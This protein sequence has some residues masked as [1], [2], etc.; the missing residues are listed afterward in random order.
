M[1]LTAMAGFMCLRLEPRPVAAMFS[2]R[3]ICPAMPTVH[4]RRN[5]GYWPDGGLA[6]VPALEP[7]SAAG[8]L[9]AC[10][11]GAMDTADRRAIRG[12]S[13]RLSANSRRPERRST[14]CQTILTVGVAGWKSSLTCWFVEPP[15]GIEP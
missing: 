9:P 8:A 10:S 12:Q 1:P 4:S 7:V 2:L 14:D 11:T 15:Y 3:L 6:Y 5:L 13:V